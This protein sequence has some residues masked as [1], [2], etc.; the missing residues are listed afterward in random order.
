[1][2]TSVRSRWGTVGGYR[3][4]LALAL[5]LILSTASWSIQHFV[6]RVFLAWHSTQSMAAALPAGMSNFVFVSFFLGLAGYVNTFV[7]QY[8]GARRPE[9]VGASIWQGSYLSLGAGVA[10]LGMLPLARPLFDLIGH[11]PA[12]RSEE[13]AYFRIL[14]FGTGPFILATALSCFY[15][16][17][18]KTWIVLIVNASAT[19]VNIGLDYVLI[20][21]HW[22]FPTM[23]IRGAAWATNLA[24]AFSA[25]L[26]G[27]L[28]L[29]RRNREEFGT[30]SQWRFDRDLFRRLLRFG[31]P[32]GVNFMLDILAFSFFVLIVGRLGTLELVATNMAF[33]VNSL[34]FMPLIGCG[35][36]VSTLVG[37]RLGQNL[38][39]KAEYCAWS[40][41]HLALGYM[42][43]MAVLYMCVP[44]WFLMPYGL[45]AHGED[46]AAA[47]TLAEGLLQIVAIYCVFDGMYIVFTSALKGAGD[48]RYVML[49]SIALSWL[50]LLIPAFVGIAYFD[51]GIWTLWAFLCAY[52]AAAGI[53]F[54]WRFKSGAWKTMRVIE[55]A[56]Q[57]VAGL[58]TN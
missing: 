50:V 17:Q 3:D 33:N 7:A 45:G 37:Q 26:F 39:D 58:E 43:T 44:E 32:S 54:Y 35:I 29:Q 19:C 31:I 56:H 6:D 12:I 46:F 57:S 52:I 21:G 51:V 4:F 55:D 28:I 27:L 25:L 22:G 14:C 18:G 16:G 38:P 48:T 13:V 41:M 11:D 10:A 53:V 40:G 20:F 5:P 8:V 30:L 24:A 36:A 2:L 23:G 9:R 42:S 1:V 34:A 15:S 47:Q 49:V